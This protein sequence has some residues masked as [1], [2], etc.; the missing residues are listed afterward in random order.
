MKV[1]DFGPEHERGGW[2]GQVG[3]RREQG[4]A[5]AEPMSLQQNGWVEN[6]ADKAKFLDF[7]C[8]A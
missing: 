1:V 6:A 5:H 4:L 2:L 8:L 7:R 3:L